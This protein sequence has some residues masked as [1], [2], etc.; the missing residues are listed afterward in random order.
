MALSC[1]TAVLW[2]RIISVIKSLEAVFG[3]N[4]LARFLA[5][6]LS[7]RMPAKAEPILKHAIIQTR[8]FSANI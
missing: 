5:L 2:Y 7:L 4:P 6:F 1:I 3:A 8:T